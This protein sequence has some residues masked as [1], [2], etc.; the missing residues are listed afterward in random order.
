MELVGTGLRWHHVDMATRDLDR[1]AKYVKAR[2][3]DLYASRKAAADSVGISK[4]TWQR[5]EEGQATRDSTYRKIDRALQWASGSCLAIGEGGEPVVADYS[6][7][8]TAVTVR[9]PAAWA[10]PSAEEV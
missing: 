3:M 7:D 4:D 10:G 2:R 5:V 6:E 9:P 1:L 8:G